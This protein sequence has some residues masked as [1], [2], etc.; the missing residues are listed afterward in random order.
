MYRRV[1]DVT[2]LLN[3][4]LQRANDVLACKVQL[5]VL[6]H[7]PV[8]VFAEREA[9]DGYV[10]TVDEVPLQQVVE[11][12]C[13][14]EPNL[15]SETAARYVYAGRTGDATDS[16]DVCHNVLPARL[17]VRNERYAV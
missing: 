2:S 15:K 1:P 6:V 8:K 5:A 3:R 7:P 9:G 12:F 11:D 4:L 13:A 10:V 14:M 16:G 17:E